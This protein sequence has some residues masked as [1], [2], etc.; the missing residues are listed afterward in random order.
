MSPGVVLLHQTTDYRDMRET[1][2]SL[3]RFFGSLGHPLTNKTVYEK[4]VQSMPD[5]HKPMF[6]DE[7]TGEVLPF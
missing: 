1:E 5:T 3:I 7:L 4:H 2:D 6:L